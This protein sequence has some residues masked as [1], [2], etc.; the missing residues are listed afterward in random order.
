MCFPSMQ[1]AE[2]YDWSRWSQKDRWCT[3]DKQSS[4]KVDVITFKNSSDGSGANVCGFKF[5]CPL[6]D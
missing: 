4:Y 2:E 3:E 1:F 6:T 5:S